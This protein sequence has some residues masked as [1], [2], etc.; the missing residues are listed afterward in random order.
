MWEKA[1]IAQKASIVILLAAEH[2]FL[3]AYGWTKSDI[4]EW[5]PGFDHPGRDKAPH[6]HG[7]AVNSLKFW[8]GGRRAGKGVWE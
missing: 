6:L 2:A 5:R 1:T 7:H 4:L 8:L 3:W